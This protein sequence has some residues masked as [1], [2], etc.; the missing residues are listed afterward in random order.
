MGHITT[1]HTCSECIL[2]Y[3]TAVLL[4]LFVCTVNPYFR[5]VWNYYEYLLKYP[6]MFD[7]KILKLP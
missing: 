1:F 6:A 7:L 3:Y 4:N 2:S 5:E